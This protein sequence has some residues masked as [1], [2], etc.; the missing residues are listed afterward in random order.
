MRN[1]AATGNTCLKKGMYIE[2][3][4]KSLKEI[5]MSRSSVRSFS[6]GPIDEEKLNEILKSAIYAP[7]AARRNWPSYYRRKES[8]CFQ[9]RHKVNGNGKRDYSLINSCNR[10]ET[11]F[12]FNNNALYSLHGYLK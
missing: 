12:C 2:H 7:Y 9:N 11:D 6:K 5:L 10:K 1:K 4:Q 8:V 3:K